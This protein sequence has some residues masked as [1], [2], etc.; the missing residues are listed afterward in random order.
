MTE[1]LAKRLQE[2]FSIERRDLELII[3][4]KD[5]Q[6]Q[7]SHELNTRLQSDYE[8]VEERLRRVQLMNSDFVAEIKVDIDRTKL[9]NKEL[10]EFRD[11]F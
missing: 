1:A 10:T 6:L 9:E 3:S 2:S 5:K 4:R 8:Y 7:A 11:K